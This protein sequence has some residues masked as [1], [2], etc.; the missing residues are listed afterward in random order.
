MPEEFRVW[1]ERVD[2]AVA[3]KAAAMSNS[4]ANGA[5]VHHLSNRMSIM[6]QYCTN[7]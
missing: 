3:K 1:K 5:A 4:I 6:Y 7:T 2:A